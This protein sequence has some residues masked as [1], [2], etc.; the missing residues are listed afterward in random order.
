LSYQITDK[1]KRCIA[2]LGAESE[3][4]QKLVEGLAGQS[5]RLLLMSQDIQK[6][7]PITDKLLGEYPLA[8]IQG[9]VCPIDAS[10]EADI[11]FITATAEKEKEMIAAIK[12]FTTQKI[13]V[14]VSDAE[15]DSP[16]FKS[17]KTGIA[18]D[19]HG[20]ALLSKWFR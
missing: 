12:N 4:A 2:V 8:D 14:S 20:R 18:C 17:R 9:T 10:W 6:L 7:S 19:G 11:V 1:V 16:Q 13:L 15:A 5:G 3:K